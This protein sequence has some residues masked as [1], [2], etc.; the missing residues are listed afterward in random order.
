LNNRTILILLS[1]I[2]CFFSVGQEKLS[3]Y[4]KKNF[5]LGI[6]SYAKKEY[7]NAVE[8]FSKVTKSYPKHSK[9]Y[10]YRGI[11]YIKSS[12]EQLA[13]LDFNHLLNTHQLEDKAHI[14]IGKI[15]MGQMNY[16]KASESFD[17][18]KKINPKN[19]LIYYQEGILYYKR[20][21]Y[22]QSIISF[23]QAI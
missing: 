23:G 22:D 10:Y 9:S 18:A 5:D 17:K 15:F 8:H 4:S 21:K 3:E 20:K 16:T 2:L 19:A 12:K 7:A 11:C 1:T 13:L 6:K 14:E